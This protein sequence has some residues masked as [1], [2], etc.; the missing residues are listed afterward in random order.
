MLKHHREYKEIHEIYNIVK[1]SILIQNGVY[2]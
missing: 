2:I 1:L